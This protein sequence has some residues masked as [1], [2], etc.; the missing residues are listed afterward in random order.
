LRFEFRFEFC[1]LSCSEFRSELRVKGPCN[2]FFDKGCDA[3]V[4]AQQ[5]DLFGPV[6]SKFLDGG[7]KQFNGLGR[8]FSDCGPCNVDSKVV[9][10]R[11]LYWTGGNWTGGIW[12]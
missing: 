10:Q 1:L 2:L 8:R 5:M 4:F 12:T 7:H 6:K 3:A 9:Q 11:S